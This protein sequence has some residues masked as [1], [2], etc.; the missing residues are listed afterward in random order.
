MKS[1]TDS[2]LTI[3][4]PTYNRPDKVK[5][6]V[7]SLIPQ[8]NAEVNLI[9]IDNHSDI[10]TSSLFSEYAL[11]D[12]VKFIRNKFNIGADANI[13]KCF[14]LC[15]TPWLWTLSDD[16]IL[17]NDAVIT[18]TSIIRQYSKAAFINFNRDRTLLCEGVQMLIQKAIPHYSSLFWM[19]ACVYNVGLLRN[20]MAD[21]FA[22]IST[23]QP[24]IVLLMS[25]GSENKY[26]NY[27]LSNAKIIENGGKAISWGRERFV[28]ASLFMYDLIRIKY[29]CYFRIIDVPIIRMCYNSA[30]EDYSKSNSFWHTFN[31]ARKIFKRRGLIDT[32]TRDKGFYFRSILSLIKKFFIKNRE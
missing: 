14:E 4:I 24:G 19:S 1:K 26:A 22:S 30:I 16:D 15:D 29:P 27:L 20:N 25:F 11:P 32:I 23:M 3:A 21:Y 28:Y 2:L 17:T 5:N 13:A 9:I 18:V 8:I 6:Q 31:L 10:E 7:L 12:N